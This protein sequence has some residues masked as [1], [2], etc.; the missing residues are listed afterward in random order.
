VATKLVLSL[1]K[2]ATRLLRRKRIRET[3]ILT[4]TATDATGSSKSTLTVKVKR[5]K[6]RGR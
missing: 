3:A 1:P 2:K 5:P 4:L 6:R